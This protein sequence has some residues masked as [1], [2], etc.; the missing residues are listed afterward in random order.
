VGF[1]GFIGI[2][3]AAAGT[4][5]GYFV[6]K[7]INALEEWIRVLFGLK[8][9]KASVYIF[10]RIPNE[11]DWRAVVWITLAAIAGAAVGALMPAIS[12]AMTQPVNVLRYE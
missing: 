5:L 8:L 12:A 9:W 3:G 7:N 1:G 6:T 10:S 4:L 11:V 2:T